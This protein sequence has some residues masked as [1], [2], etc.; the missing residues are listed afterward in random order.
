[1]QGRG[2]SCQLYGCAGDSKSR[3]LHGLV[4]L[5]L[6]RIEEAREGVM[7]EAR[8]ECGPPEVPVQAI[9]PEALQQ[10]AVVAQAEA[11]AAA[12][13]VCPFCCSAFGHNAPSN[14]KPAETSGEYVSMCAGA[15]KGG[16]TSWG[17]RQHGAKRGA[18]CRAGR[19]GLAGGCPAGPPAAAAA[20]APRQRGRPPGRRPC[21]AHQPPPAKVTCC[22]PLTA[23]HLCDVGAGVRIWLHAS[24]A[25]E[26]AAFALWHA[27]SCGA[28]ERALRV[29]ARELACCALSEHAQANNVAALLSRLQ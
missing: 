26:S 24:R 28:G 12:A 23:P 8:G 17:Q 1:M 16:G 15:C 11:I 14:I 29:H 4:S 6:L 21:P 20:G 2:V 18:G 7:G 27:S 25:M 13:Q 22:I 3:L 10:A 5:L 19:C 9:T